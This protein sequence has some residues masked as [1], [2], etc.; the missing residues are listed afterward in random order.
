MAI[1]PA[2][3]HV[4][5]A[6]TDF[7]VAYLQNPAASIARRA[8]PVLNVPKQSDKFFVYT[9]ADHM[10]TEMQ[11]RA[12]GT[13][14]AERHFKLSTDTYYCDVLS[15]AHNVSRQLTANADPA[16]DPEEDAVK[17][18]LQDAMIK[19]EIDWAT[20]AF[21]SSWG[22]NTSPGT[23]WSNAAAYPL[24]DITTGIRTIL[25]AT[26]MRP[27]VLALGADV[28]YTGLS[29]H[30]DILARMPETSARIV[31]KEFV[32]NL[33]G[34]DEI[35]V[36]EVVYNSAQEGL[37]ASNAFAATR[38]SALLFY[39]NASPGRLTANAGATFAWT[40]LGGAGAE[41]Q[42]YDVPKDD[43]FPRIELNLARDFKITGSALGYYLTSCVS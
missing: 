7:T 23:V 12:P 10:K 41:V 42:R 24:S 33:L 3:A 16:I 35:L 36:S 5:S 29:L 15:L 6:L 19:E 14:A 40:G 17:F 20:I 11:K 1:S 37:A 39:R 26:G 9:I 27:N 30:E 18:L 32:A 25:L 31:T 8:F 43:A 22:T 4:D 2:D 21:A 28:W 13:P 38:T 34:L